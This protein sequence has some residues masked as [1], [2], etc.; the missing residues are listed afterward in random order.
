MQGL[1]N[2]SLCEF[3]SVIS[4]ET[5][6]SMDINNLLIILRISNDPI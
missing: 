6:I 2:Y 4:S 5:F 3:D 1:K